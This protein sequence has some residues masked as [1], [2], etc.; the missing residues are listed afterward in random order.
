MQE[1]LLQYIWQHQYLQSTGLTTVQGQ[2]LEVLDSGTWN[3]EQ[4]PDFLY[5]RVR[6]GDTLW[7]GQVEI[8]VRASD[9]YK[10][11]H[12]GDA[13]YRNIVL[14]VVWEQDLD[15]C[16][17]ELPTLQLRDWVSLRRLDLYA[18]WM[19]AP[20]GIACA[21]NLQRVSEQDWLA[22][23]QSL[24]LERMLQKGA[25]IQQRVRVM[26]G[27]WKSV[28]WSLIFR[29]LGGKVN[30]AAFEQVFA[31]LGWPL[32]RKYSKKSEYLEALLLGT[33]GILDEQSFNMGAGHLSGYQKRYQQLVQKHQLD[34]KPVRMKQLRM[35]PVSFPLLRMR[36]AVRLLREAPNLF[37]QVG[38]GLSVQAWQEL[39]RSGTTEKKKSD[40]AKSKRELDE[41]VSSLGKSLIDSLIIN[42]ILPMTTVYPYGQ[43]GKRTVS[44]VVEQLRTLPPEHHHITR[45]WRSLQVEVAQARDSQAL[46]QLFE[47]YCQ[48]KNCLAC[49]VGQIC[50]S[51]PT[52]PNNT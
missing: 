7:A 52:G 42:V 29:Y 51:D 43:F 9:W 41:G 35:R 10:H 18:R 26:G 3:Q 8:H 28:F 32:L 33:A 17:G 12:E 39:L 25:A 50:L 24:A 44:S 15:H 37:E 45:I 22:W 19:E 36:Q 30:G 47:T 2:T 11:A 16:P 20:K 49:R 38:N 27:D 46:L 48:Q 31:Q 6:I 23:K 1:R 4:G 40:D 14:H 34:P 5:A 13:F 21:G